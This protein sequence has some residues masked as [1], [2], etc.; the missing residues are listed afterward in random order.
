M[1]DNPCSESLNRATPRPAP[2]S[3]INFYPILM[4]T[5][6]YQPFSPPWLGWVQCF[7]TL[8]TGFWKVPVVPPEQYPSSD[9]LPIAVRHCVVFLFHFSPK[10][11]SIHCHCLWLSSNS[12]Q[13]AFISVHRTTAWRPKPQ[14]SVAVMASRRSS[15]FSMPLWKCLCYFSIKWPFPEVP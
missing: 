15:L 3:S 9:A 5:S 7:K 2:R 13:L 10:I 14:K 12:S 4:Y 11:L 6:S 8:N 1:W